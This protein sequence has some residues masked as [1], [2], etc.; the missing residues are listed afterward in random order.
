MSIILEKLRNLIR[1]Q[2]WNRPGYFIPPTLVEE[3]RFKYRQSVA[4]EIE[5]EIVG[6][7]DI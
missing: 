4:E 1:G 3:M 2:K 7:D 6:T 5:V